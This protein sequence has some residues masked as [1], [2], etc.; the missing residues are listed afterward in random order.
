MLGFVISTIIFSLV[1]YFLN[2]Y[3]DTQGI[4]STGS[5]KIIVLTTATLISIGAGWAVDK[6]DGDAELHQKDS[7]IADV[8]N[9]GDPVKMAKLLTGVN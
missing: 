1:A 5:R 4:S 3:L 7:S 9:S 8:M 6:I 2:R